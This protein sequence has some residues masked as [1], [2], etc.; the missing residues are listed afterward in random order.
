MSILRGQGYA[1]N[2]QPPIDVT[3]LP[4][5]TGQFDKVFFKFKEN[6]WG[7]DHEFIATLR[8]STY[9]Y[10]C[11]HW[12]NLDVHLPGSKLLFCLL[13]DEGVKKNI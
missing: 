12:Q 5:W 9:R 7:T 10:I 2:F 13:S 4:F 8:N 3:N 6:F 11:N 1:I